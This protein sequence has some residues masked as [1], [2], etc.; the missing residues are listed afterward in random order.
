MKTWIAGICLLLAVTMPGA[1]TADAVQPLDRAG[2]ARLADAAAHGT[3]TIVALWSTDC[4][5]CKKNLKLF[6]E[7]AAADRGLRVVTVA[8]QPLA[9]DLAA[10]LD[11]LVV[12]GNRFAYGSDAP[13]ALAYALDPAWRGELP[14]TLL[15]DGRG[16]RV[17][18]TGVLDCTRVL[19]ALG[20]RSP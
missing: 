11:R 5:H 19:A 3:P 7:L 12:P 9:A 14:R 10:P 8:A 18:L 17:A 20:R 16:G 15:F 2:A 6:S 1:V 4:V 13:E